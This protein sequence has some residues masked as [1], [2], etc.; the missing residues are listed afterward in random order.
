M[1]IYQQNFTEQFIKDLPID[2]HKTKNMD[3]NTIPKEYHILFTTDWNWG[4]YSKMSM[5]KRMSLH[6][7][8]LEYQHNDTTASII[9]KNPVEEQ[10][11]MGFVKD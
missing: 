5:D 8:F 3:L 4:R 2:F 7:L 10:K 11:I 6:R 1:N 9:Q